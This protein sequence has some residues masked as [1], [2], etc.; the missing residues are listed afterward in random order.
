MVSLSSV[1]GAGGSLYF[2]IRQIELKGAGANASYCISGMVGDGCDEALIRVELGESAQVEIIPICS[3][4]GTGGML[5]ER[6][7]KG[8]L[9]RLILEALAHIYFCVE[10]ASGRRTSARVTGY[11]DAGRLFH[12]E[13][14]V[15]KPHTMH[16]VAESGPR[17]LA[18]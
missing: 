17:W 14:T 18:A 2:E 11:A 9:T 10:S 5:D 13:R 6:V 12:L 8:E 16:K 1:S 4:D 15:V 3:E 7:G